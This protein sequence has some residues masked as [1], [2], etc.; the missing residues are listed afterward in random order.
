MPPC[1]TA[2][3]Y[4]SKPNEGSYPFSEVHKEDSIVHANSCT[5]KTNCDSE[6]FFYPI[7]SVLPLGLAAEF[8]IFFLPV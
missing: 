3:F 8:L 7:C 2:C 6:H 1:V 4:L 5:G